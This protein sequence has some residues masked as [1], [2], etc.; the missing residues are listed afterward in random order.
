MLA[1]NCKRPKGAKGQLKLAKGLLK[2]KRQKNV[3]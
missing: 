3:D 2:D 1:K